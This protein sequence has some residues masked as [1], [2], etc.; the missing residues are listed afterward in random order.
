MKAN[1]LPVKFAVV[2]H[3][4]K[5]KSSI[6]STLAKDE[7]VGISAMSGTTRFAEAIQVESKNARYWL[8]DTPGFQRPGKV[9]AW[10]KQR[11][12]NAAERSKLVA[13]FVAD[14]DCQAQFPDEV[15]LLRPLV[16]GAAILYVVDGSRPF[17]TEYEAE[18]EIL[19]WTGRP[20]MALINPIENTSH[21]KQWQA[22]LEQYFK[23]V[24]V[25]NP[26]TADFDK[27]L[28]LLSAFA[29]LNPDWA[30]TI[31]QLIND[32]RQERSEKRQAAAILLARLLEDVCQHRQSQKV[33]TRQQA[34]LLQTL[35]SSQYRQWLENRENQAFEQLFKLYRHANTQYV[36]QSLE[37]PP[38]LFDCEQ[39]Y[40]W[41]LNKKQLALA[42][43][44]AGSSAGA[45]IDLAVAGH[46]FFL[47]ALL[48]GAA[49]FSTAW[50]SADRLTAMDI[51]GLPLGGYQASCG[52]ISN[53][54]FPYVIIGRFVYLF[55][56]I[57]QRNHACRTVMTVDSGLL[58]RQIA[59]LEK[60]AQRDLHRACEK[61]VKQKPVDDLAS[62]L[63]PLLT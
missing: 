10:L 34:E 50:L 16:E 8:V 23:T 22:A 48:G 21:L 11:S 17:G 43:A 32:L 51:K 63:L 54:N 55:N 44:A 53:R 60:S 52:P 2:G 4:N 57:S 47:G 45:A 59:G 41:G 33:L 49:G 38:A 62:L 58:T 39:W 36:L 61:L 29:H 27:Q 42:S 18:M 35:L 6:V 37:M 12:T 5:G 9:L 3:P 7:S 24:R 13:S 19:R 40:M 28:E 31:A 30:E 46:S 20:S 25:F 15:E 14:P 26:M 1:N 56:Q